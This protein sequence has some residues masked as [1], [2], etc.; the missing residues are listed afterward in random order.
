MIYCFKCDQDRCDHRFEEMLPVAER[1]RPVGSKCPACLDG[2]IIRDLAAET[3][4]AMTD[5]TVPLESNAAGVLPN[6]VAEAR[7]YAKKHGIP[8]EYKRDGTAM[9]KSKRSRD[10]ALRALGLV[11]KSSWC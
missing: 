11:D 4:G 2:A 10:R 5:W 1:E 3:G 8:I 7:D 9:F 6:Q